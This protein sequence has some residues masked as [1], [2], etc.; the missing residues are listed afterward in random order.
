M[1][2][3]P[4]DQP[5]VEASKIATKKVMTIYEETKVLPRPQ[6]PPSAQGFAFYVGE[7]SQTTVDTL[8]NLDRHLERLCAWPQKGDYIALLAYLNMTREH[9]HMLQQIRNVLGERTRCATTLGFGPRFLHS[10]GQAHKGGP[11]SGVFLQF[12]A[13]EPNDL[14]IPGRSYSFGVVQ[15]A[16]AMG[17]FAVLSE[18]DRRALGIQLG[19]DTIPSLRMFLQDLER[20]LS[21]TR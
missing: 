5:D 3:N 19:S 15:M 1:G 14:D 9:G 2:I 4:F 13:D 11:N 20:C 21:R 7:Q 8:G 16:Q 18:R 10:T 6:S 17:D 12:T